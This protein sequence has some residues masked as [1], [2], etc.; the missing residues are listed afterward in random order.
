VAVPFVSFVIVPID[1]AAC[2]LLLAWPWA[3]TALLHVCARL[4][5]ALWWLLV[6]LAAWPA[7]MQYLPEASLLAFALACVG[8][9]WLLAPRGVPARAL[10]VALLLPLCLSRRALPAVGAFRATVIDVGQGLS[11]LVRTRSHALLFDT[12]ARYPSGFDLGEAAVVPTLHALG[13][14]RLDRLVISHGDN[15]HSGGAVSVLAAYPGTP[16]WGG[17]PTRGPVPMQQCHA[18]QTWQWDDVEFRILRPPAPVTVKGNDAGCV[19]LVTGKAGRL[20]LPADTSSR[21]EPDIARAVPAGPPLVLVAPHH[22][23][24]TSSSRAY[25][26]ALQPR[27]AIASTGYLN[28]YHHPASVI[29]ARYKTLG[30]PLLNTPATGAVR[31]AFPADAAPR[32]AAEERVRQAR[33]W[34]EHPQPLTSPVP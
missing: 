7:A 4:V 1:L 21:V 15:D 26:E 13:V 10:G 22:G 18:G 2:A 20:L 27:F 25:L 12:G 30:I 14:T 23:S 16:V 9:V 34:R 33:Y 31:F 24:K 32:V 6:H 8:A 29:A 19:L 17:E 11:V 5:D 3:G 28:G